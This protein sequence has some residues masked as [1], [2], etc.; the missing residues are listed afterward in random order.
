MQLT[1]KKI[2]TKDTI[3]KFEANSDAY[4]QPRLQIERKLAGSFRGLWANSKAA[5]QFTRIAKQ[6]MASK[7]ESPQTLKALLPTQYKAG[8]RRFTP[9]DPYMEALNQS[10]VELIS[11]P[12]E[13]VEG[14][15]IITTDKKRRAYDIIMCGTGF[16]PYTPRFPIQGRE[17]AHLSDLWSA[18]GG[19]ESYLAVTVANFPNLFGTSP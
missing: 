12:I 15:A 4:F 19:Y 9:A 14:N 8:C 1:R 7:I 11:T 2:D 5:E 13:R 3:E 17:G 10:N 6:H 18:D 16:E